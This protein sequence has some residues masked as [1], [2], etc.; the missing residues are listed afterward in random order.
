MIVIFKESFMKLKLFIITMLL[1]ALYSPLLA[2][3]G[4]EA[5]VFN[6]SESDVVTFKNPDGY[7]DQEFEELQKSYIDPK[8]VNL[9]DIQKLPLEQMSNE[10]IQRLIDIIS[11]KVTTNVKVDMIN[12]LNSILTKRKEKMLTENVTKMKPIKRE[13]LEYKKDIFPQ[14]LQPKVKR[15]VIRNKI[16]MNGN[17]PIFNT[18]AGG[19]RN[20]RFA[21]NRMFININGLSNEGIDIYTWYST[22]VNLID[23]SIYVK[24]VN[25]GMV[26]LLKRFVQHVKRS[27]SARFH[28]TW[29]KPQIPLGKYK[30]LAVVKF[31]RGNKVLNRV[32]K[33][34]GSANN[35]TYIVFKN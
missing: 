28:F 13:S 35:D 3:K 24:N 27:G 20:I 1:Q 7:K 21:N 12:Y 23:A 10:F 16:N 29:I 6:N 31:Q 22:G 32:D 34:W 25:N 18:Q 17:N 9:E 8:F 11:K 30:I 26:Y 15:I 2:Q 4:D 14:T 5:S 33:Y 19:V